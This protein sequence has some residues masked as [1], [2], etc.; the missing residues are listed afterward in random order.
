LVLLGKQQVPEFG[1]KS[2]LHQEPGFD[3]KPSRI[4]AQNWT[5]AAEKFWMTMIHHP[6]CA[7]ALIVL[8]AVAMKKFKPIGFGA[9]ALLLAFAGDAATE[10]QVTRRGTSVLHYKTQNHLVA[11]E[12]GSNVSG[13]LRLQHNE[14]GHSSKQTLHL[15]VAGLE[16]NTSYNLI[17][18]VGDDTNAIPVGELTTDQRGRGRVTYTLRGQDHGGKNPLPAPLSPLTDLR[19]L[20]IENASTQIVAHA[21]IAD[22]EKFQYLIKR[23]LTASAPDGTA[24]GSISLIANTQ[25]VNFR[26]LAGG[27]SSTNDYHLAL[28]SNVVS[29][30]T[31]DA[32]GRLEIREWP[33]GS[34]AILDLR[35]LSLMD[36]S[37][38]SVLHTVLPK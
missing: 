10:K 35:A 8:N 28:N 18:L 12:T 36:S 15:S 3:I 4:S 32:D 19:S 24:A 14:Q 16:P 2:G 27:L 29:T 6:V 1:R 23:N 31:S 11:T 22:A 17:A 20:G 38:N 33:V 13:G 9:A 37:S 25:R 30:V 7:L 21:W 5:K 26:L 34:P